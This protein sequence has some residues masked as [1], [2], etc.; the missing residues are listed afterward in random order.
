MQKAEQAYGGRDGSTY[1][2]AAK[3]AEGLR[4]ARRWDAGSGRFDAILS[5]WGVEFSS[6]ARS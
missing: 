1:R 5:P 4:D 3:S 6:S 2:S